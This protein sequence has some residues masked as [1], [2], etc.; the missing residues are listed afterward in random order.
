M[1]LRKGLSIY[2]FIAFI[3]LLLP[4]SA[5]KRGV[6]KVIVQEFSAAG[7]DASLAKAAEEAI[8]IEV[9]GLEG[10]SVITSFELKEIVTYAERGVDLGCE[11]SKECL[12]EV[13]KKLEA[14]FLI[15]GRIIVLGTD[16]V[17]SLNSV[18]IEK[19]ASGRRVSATGTSLTE[20]KKSIPDMVSD[21]FGL[22]GKKPKFS[23]NIDESIKLAIMPLSSTGV[24]ENEAL[25]LTQIMAAEINSVDKIGVVSQD[26]IKAM[27]DKVNIDSKVAC[28]DDV[29]CVVEIGAAF[30]AAKL[31]TGD[32]GKI[33]D[34]YIISLKLIDT[35]RADVENRVVEVFSGDR[36]E[37][38][39]AIKLSVYKM[40]GID[41][42]S[43]RGGVD[44]TFNIKSGKII[45]LERSSDLSGSRYREKSLIPGRYNLKVV[46]D[47]DGYLPLQTDIYVAPGNLN[48]R[49]FYLVER[50]IPWYK[51]WWFWTAAGVVVTA[52]AGTTYYLTKDIPPGSGIM[53]QEKQQ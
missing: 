45:L 46:P 23:L 52:A 32:V 35:R 31:V 28:L 24:A 11:E 16:F 51:S 18:D 10:F 50:Q 38:K 29:E 53:E 25:A 13:Q 6:K 49:S 26:D 47:D 44:F 39:H 40:L 2:I 3:L 42:S 5:E 33:E 22:S 37:L 19:G 17:L 36:S 9:S 12:V 15:A 41:T 34:S 4:L 8:A 1:N 48:V 14:D 43:E 21:L 27:L 7:V 30:G 20:L